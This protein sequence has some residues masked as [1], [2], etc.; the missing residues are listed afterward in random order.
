[1][2]KHEFGIMQIAPV[3]GQ[4][5]DDYEPEKYDCISIP[6]DDMEPLLKELSDIMCFWHTVDT[7]G[8]GLAYYGITLIPPFSMKE[9]LSVVEKSSNLAPLT[10][11]LKT[12]LSENK[13]MIHFGI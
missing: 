2:A 1:M 9:M 12:A 6:D 13:Y 5:F 4:R 10:G 8:K 11:L 3:T 7:P